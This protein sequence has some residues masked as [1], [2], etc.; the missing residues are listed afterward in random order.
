MSDDATTDRHESAAESAD[1]M[2]YI[3]WGALVVL[4]ALAV[5]ALLRFYTSAS[6]AIAAW[7]VPAYEPAFQASFNL[8]VLLACG[9]G[10]SLLARELRD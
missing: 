8:V 7:V 3:Q 2:T 10:V 6:A 1:V 5:V 9:V 4:V